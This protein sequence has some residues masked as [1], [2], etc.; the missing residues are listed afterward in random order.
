LHCASRRHPEAANLKEPGT[1]GLLFFLRRIPD[2]AGLG[3]IA[4]VKSIGA[5]IS[6]P[7]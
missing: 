6:R 2:K 3:S 5:N 4:F 7:K 1:A